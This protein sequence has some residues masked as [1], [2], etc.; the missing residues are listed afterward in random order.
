MIGFREG[1]LANGLKV[2]AE[3]NDGAQSV[4]LGVVVDTGARDEPAA[5][6]G[7]SH[8]LEHMVFKGSARLDAEAINL[9]FDDLGAK[10]NA[11]TAEEVTAYHGA[12]L[13]E[14]QDDL[15]RLLGELMH[16]SFRPADLDTERQVIVEEIG[17]YQDQPESRLFDTLRPAYYGGHP[18]GNSVLGTPET[19][20]SIDSRG[21]GAY[22]RQHY[23]ASTALLVA[24]GNVNW[25]AL[26]DVGEE[27]LGDWPAGGFDRAHPEFTPQATA[28]LVLT[29]P[30]VARAHLGLL[31][32]GWP[33]QDPRREDAALLA[34]II[35]DPENSRLYWRLVDSGLADTA[36]FGHEPLD[37]VGAYGGYASCDPDRAQQVLDGIR[38]VLAGVQAGGVTEAE[39]ERA[40]RKSAMSTVLRAETPYGRLLTLGVEY[41]V[42]GELLSLAEDVRRIRA[43][44][45]DGVNALL[46]PR[47]FDQLKVAAL[48]PISALN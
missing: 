45:L 44:T 21:M 14:R 39:L 30:G 37:R 9:A 34:A 43:V 36:D 3:V 7:V 48:G 4:A 24:T 26:M 46:E 29:D 38:E 16:P 12:V 1:A 10:Y 15:L 23:S 33:V 28:P 31:A 2:V 20:A 47:P 5:I 40:K 41:L 22:F 27:T 42:S 25:D 11:F 18:A 8:F 32:P 17:M 6:S 13:P 19:L 35:G